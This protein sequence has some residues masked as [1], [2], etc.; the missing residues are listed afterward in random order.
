MGIF[1]AVNKFLGS[2][3]GGI[4]TNVLGGLFDDKRQRDN[5]EDQF[6]F[7]T[8]K[9]LTP[10]E[11]NSGGGGQGGVVRASGSTLGNAPQVQ[12]QAQRD[13]VAKEAALERENK[14]T[15]ADIQTGPAHKKADI[16]GR[17]EP[18]KRQQVSATVTKL[19]Q[20]IK[21]GKIELENFWPILF[22]KMGPDNLMVAMASM[23]EGVS[24]EQVLKTSGIKADTKTRRQ[25]HEVAAWLVKYK[26]IQGGAEGIHKGLMDRGR[27][28]LG[29]HE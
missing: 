18:Y 1:K 7:L 29:V 3:I 12:A 20:D 19:K 26:G 27:N 11:I 2:G 17:M 4:A 21:R 16:E 5:T 15:V 10:W 24:P 23:L 8:S 25:M 13:F 14:R 9:G 22:A 28:I 6:D